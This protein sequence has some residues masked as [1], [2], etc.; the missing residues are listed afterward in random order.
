MELRKI[1]VSQGYKMPRLGNWLVWRNNDSSWRCWG[2]RLWPLSGVTSRR[3]SISNQRLRN[4]LLAAQITIVITLNFFRLT[5]THLSPTQLRLFY[6]MGQPGTNL[7]LLWQKMEFNTPWTRKTGIQV[8][9]VV[10]AD[11]TSTL[12]HIKQSNEYG[13]YIDESC[14]AIF[15]VPGSMIRK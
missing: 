1:I 8:W 15:R 10:R 4:F 14:D 9:V 2:S 12:A 5:Y 6:I 11:T 7:N 3:D 13:F